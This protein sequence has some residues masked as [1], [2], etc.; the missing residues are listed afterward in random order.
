MKSN[1]AAGQ[2]IAAARIFDVPR[3]LHGAAAVMQKDIW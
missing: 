3:I 1:L 2:R